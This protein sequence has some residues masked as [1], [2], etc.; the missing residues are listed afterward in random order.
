MDPTPLAQS[1]SGQQ[2]S[3]LFSLAR[4]LDTRLRQRSVTRRRNFAL[5]AF[6]LAECKRLELFRLLGFSSVT[7]YAHSVNGFGSSKTSSLIRIAEASEQLP[8]IREAFLAGQVDWC[9][10]R[11]IVKKATPEDEADWLAKAKVL[12]VTELTALVQE[13]DPVYRRLLELSGEELAWVEAVADGIRQEGGPFALGKAIAEACRRIAMGEMASAGG[14]GFRVVINQCGECKEATRETSEGPVPVSPEDV[15]MILCDAEVLDIRGG[16]ARLTRTVPPKIRNFVKARDKGRCVVP[17][18]RNRVVHF[19]HEDGW[20]SG[21]DPSRCFGLCGSCHQARHRGTLRV[22]GS[23]PDVR[24]FLA[25][26]TYIGRA[27][28]ARRAIAPVNSCEAA[29]ASVVVSASSS[30][31]AGA[32]SPGDR[33]VKASP[34][35]EAS[36]SAASSGGTALVVSPHEEACSGG[37]VASPSRIRAAAEEARDPIVDAVMALRSLKLSARD[38]KAGVQRVLQQHPGRSWEAGALA[39]AALRGVPSANAVTNT[40]AIPTAE[41]GAA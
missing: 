30:A 9:A 17:G 2:G 36:A 3:P 41:N 14:P 8:L 7:A 32:G 4:K 13:K 29:P 39:A 11:E 1:A 25:D 38:A 6:D 10:A 15:E 28:D 35:A 19:H 12:T 27:G 26:G 34:H 40:P 31:F 24:F 33:A 5:D 16:P 21:H 23:M 37:A 22:E 18:C 20:R